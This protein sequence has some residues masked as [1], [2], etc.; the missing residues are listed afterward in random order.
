VSPRDGGARPNNT[1]P[2]KSASSAVP[3][4]GIDTNWYLDSGSTDHITNDPDRITPQERNGGH[5]QIHAAN[6][7]GMS[8]GH[9][10]TSSFH[11]P[12]RNFTFN[13]V[14]HVPDASK[15]LPSV[16]QFTSDNDVYLE[17]HPFFLLC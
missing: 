7:K 11:T 14:L 17:F 1:G 4:Y 6:G 8:I 15:N 13:N 16:H 12:H 3:S 10:G 5:D 2:K 9:V